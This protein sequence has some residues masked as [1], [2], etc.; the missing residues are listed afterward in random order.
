MRLLSPQ[1]NSLLSPTNED[2]LL[3][4]LLAEQKT[5]RGSR[6]GLYFS[7]ETAPEK[8]GKSTTFSAA[9]SANQ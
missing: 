4:R 9:H 1:E 3:Y 2:H 8:K 6:I 5:C 7:A